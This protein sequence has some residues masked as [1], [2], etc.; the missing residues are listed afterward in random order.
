M[1]VDIMIEMMEIMIMF[2]T[3]ELVKGNKIRR[4]KNQL[5]IIFKCFSS[6]SV[7]NQFINFSVNLYLHQ[8]IFVHDQHKTF[9]IF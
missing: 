7:V 9:A 1:I 3:K 2:I 4:D 8:L 6:F 5:V